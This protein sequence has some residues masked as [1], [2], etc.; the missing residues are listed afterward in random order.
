MKDLN[1]NT[2]FVVL[3][4]LALGSVFWTSYVHERDKDNITKLNNGE[5]VYEVVAACE[6][7]DEAKQAYW[8]A[9]A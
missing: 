8:T 6:T 4:T 2:N 3:R 7:M 1:E 5:V 9:I